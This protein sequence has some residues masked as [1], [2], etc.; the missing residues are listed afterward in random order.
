MDWILDVIRELLI[1]KSDSGIVIM[2]NFIFL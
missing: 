2:E 1:F